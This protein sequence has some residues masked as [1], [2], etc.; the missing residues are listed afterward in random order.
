MEYLIPALLAS[1]NNFYFHIQIDWFLLIHNQ[2]YLY[3]QYYNYLSHY[4]LNLV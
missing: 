4:L 3:L 1:N 2:F